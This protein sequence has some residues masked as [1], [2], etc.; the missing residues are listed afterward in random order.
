MATAQVGG[1]V[2]L[3]K[4]VSIEVR[5]K[6]LVRHGAIH[7]KDMRFKIENPH[8]NV[9]NWE[10]SLSSEHPMAPILRTPGSGIILYHKET[11]ITSG[12]TLKPEFTSVPS[13][14]RGTLRFAGVTDDILL[15]D[16]LAWPLPTSANIADQIGLTDT[17]EGFAETLIHAFVSANVGPLAP[18][19]R[20][21]ERLVMGTDG[22][23]GGNTKKSATFDVLGELIGGIAKVAD[24]GFRV[25]QRAGVLQ[26]ETYL[27]RD[28]T[29]E[30]RLDVLNGTLA[31]QRLTI[32]APD[33]THA[34]VIGKG[35]DKLATDPADFKPPPS[36][37]LYTTTESIQ[38]EADWGRRVEKIVNATS[39]NDPAELQQ[40]AL[41][42]LVDKGYTNV[43]VQVS[44]MDNSNM[45]FV[46]EWG[47]GDRV[48]VI[49]DGIEYTSFVSNFQMRVDDTGF[50]L[51]AGLGDPADFDPQ[52]AL[53]K[54]VAQTGARISALERNG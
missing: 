28:R 6:S 49:V 35:R 29:S 15:A 48:I 47:V 24:L 39:T 4:D 44:P 54:I 17:R 42:E 23:R 7:H 20:R 5:D 9:G 40:A 18:A 51:G 26:F 19:A 46:D 25:V 45:V 31:A 36:Y 37:Q 16:L 52:V 32:N 3:Q 43:S 8:N 14:P 50:Y 1:A 38:G 33:L 12:P 27:I 22:S 21:D 11:E 2:V 34:I 53:R 13:D 30:I 41:E 10:M